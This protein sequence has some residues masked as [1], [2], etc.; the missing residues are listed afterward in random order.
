MRWGTQQLAIVQQAAA[1]AAVQQIAHGTIHAEHVLP[2]RPCRHGSHNVGA[3][4]GC[5]LWAQQADRP[6]L[7]R[8]PM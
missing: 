5:V 7:Q 2:R 8:I 6:C 4:V 3:L 1:S